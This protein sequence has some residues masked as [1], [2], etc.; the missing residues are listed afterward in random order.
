MEREDRSLTLAQKKDRWAQKPLH[1]RHF[2]IVNGP[3]ISRQTSYLWL[4][5]GELIP[6]TEGFLLAIQDQVI[7]TRN[8]LK[9]IIRDPSIESDK[10]RRCQLYQET[11]DH[12][13]GGCKLLAGTDYTE[14]HNNAAKIIHLE[15]SRK[16]DLIHDS[17]PYYKYQ[18]PPVQENQKVKLYWDRTIY[19][20][21]TIIHN[22]P[23][24][25]IVDKQT[26][27]TFLIDI[28]VPNDTNVQ[29]KVEEKLQKY[30]P[31]AMEVREL[32]GQDDVTVI[33]LI[34]SA[35]GIIPHSLIQNLEKL[36]VS[37]TIVG[38]IQKAVI[39]NTCSIVRKFLNQ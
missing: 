11:I 35:T 38:R 7:P 20:D 3:G 8:Y 37:N 14:R 13:T 21:K 9:Y 10:C 16:Y 5:R 24:I 34:V 19:T 28:A 29:Q 2:N 4:K 15:L 30:Q 33:P 32:W 25:T 27:K 39:L 31:L 26:K 18:P 22:R 36:E 23:D 1:G 6:E 12:I 17:P